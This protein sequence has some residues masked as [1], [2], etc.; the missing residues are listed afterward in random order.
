MLLLSLILFVVV[1]FIAAI[2]LERR[3]EHREYGGT[4]YEDSRRELYLDILEEA[5][6]QRIVDTRHKK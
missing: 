3:L 5:H 2:V 4:S 6:T 1:L